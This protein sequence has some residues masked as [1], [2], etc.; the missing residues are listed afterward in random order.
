VLQSLLVIA[1]EQPIDAEKVPPANERRDSID[2]EWR[3]E[4]AF[5]G[6]A[7]GGAASPAQTT[8]GGSHA[9]E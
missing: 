5:A 4:P 6:G 1:G 3:E 9:V 2:R 8:S 7:F